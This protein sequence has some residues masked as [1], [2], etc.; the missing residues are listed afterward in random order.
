[1]SNETTQ[2]GPTSSAGK[3]RCSQNATTHGG[4]SEKLIVAGE[5]RED[6]EAL[7]NDLLDEFSPATAHA[8]GMVEDAAMARWYL[9][10][11]QRAYNAIETAL[12]AAEPDEAKWS[13]EAHQKVVLADRY[14]TAAERALKR[15]FNNIQ[16]LRKNGQEDRREARFGKKEELQAQLAAAEAADS[17]RAL[18]TKNWKTA[19]NGFDRPTLIQ[20]ITVAVRYGATETIMSPS[21]AELMWELDRELYPPEQ[22][23]RQFHF[24]NG[25]PPEYYSF[26]DND[27]YRREKGHTIDQQ[28][29]IDIWR[30]IAEEEQELGTGHAV[31][32]RDLDE[33][34]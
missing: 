29:S 33:L 27:E 14:K 34:P 5:R 4:T 21:N 12:Y 2:T 24:P 23:C 10:R 16:V 1:M 17:L 15:A 20:K 22:V 32:G 11:K 6:F 3:E 7:L 30:E 18:E 13:A 19:C 8:R 25:I 26:T 9:W 28:L 31:P